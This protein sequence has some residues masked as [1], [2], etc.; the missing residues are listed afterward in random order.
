MM[1]ERASIAEFLGRSYVAIAFLAALQW[2][3]HGSSDAVEI[4]CAV[5]ELVGAMTADELIG[6]ADLA[7]MAA[8]PRSSALR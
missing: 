7:L 1:C 5:A 3:A 2:L 4:T 6:A 8:K